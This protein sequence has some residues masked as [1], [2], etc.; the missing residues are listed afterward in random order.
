MREFGNR[1]GA[2]CLMML[3]EIARSWLRCEF[4]VESDCFDEAAL[5]A[6]DDLPLLLPRRHAG[7]WMSES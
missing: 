5:Y 3:A 6:D 4:S 1:S 7:V 2:N